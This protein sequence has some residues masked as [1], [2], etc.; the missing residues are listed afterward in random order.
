MLAFLPDSGCS[1]P[2]VQPAP[3]RRPGTRL[4]QSRGAPPAAQPSPAAGGKQAPW[5]PALHWADACLWSRAE[6]QERN[7][8]L[9]VI[10]SVSF[11]AF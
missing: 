8:R 6:L 3:P 4:S 10:R 7:P 5:P 2:A 1:T 11:G 9:S